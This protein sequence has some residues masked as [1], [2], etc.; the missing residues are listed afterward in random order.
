MQRSVAEIICIAIIACLLTACQSLPG[1]I[2]RQC[3]SVSAGCEDAAQRTAAALA[4]CGY[5]NV[6]VCCGH[7][8]PQGE[9]HAWVEYTDTS[10]VRWIVDPAELLREN[11][12]GPGRV[13]LRRDDW[14]AWYYRK[15]E[16]KQ[17]NYCESL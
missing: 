17:C 9:Q 3:A 15:T 7:A 6:C 1:T 13:V 2:A 4:A 8:Y 10:S 12:P 11:I 14:P 16:E 5:N